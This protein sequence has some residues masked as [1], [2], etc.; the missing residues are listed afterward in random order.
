[1]RWPPAAV[2]QAPPRGGQHT[3]PFRT[4][5]LVAASTALA[6]HR[7]TLVYRLERIERQL[8]RPWRDCRAMLTLYVV[9]L[10]DQVTP[11][12]G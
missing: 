8:E 7:N 1:M 3:D 10:A 5:V 12:S 11:R 9:C 6:I 4:D 2:R